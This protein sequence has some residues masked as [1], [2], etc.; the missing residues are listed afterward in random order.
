[1][2]SKIYLGEVTHAR[3]DPVKHQFRYPLYF[4]AFSLGELTQLDRQ[5][6]L[7]G[8]N[9]LRPV[10]IHDRDYLTPGEAP[11]REKLEDILHSSGLGGDLGEVVLVTAARYFNYI[12]NPISFFY[13]YDP[14]GA[15][16]CVLAQVNNTFGEMHLYP[17]AAEG[18][19]P[20]DGIRSLQVDKRF[21]VSPFFPRRGHYDFRL[22]EPGTSIDN[23]IRYHVDD[24]LSL[25]ARIHGRA[26]PLTAAA[27]ARTLM[28]HP[29]CASL[30]KPR[31]LWQAARLYWQRRLPVYPK[32]VP[33][34]ALTLRPAPP[35]LADRLGMA[36]T[37]KFLS[38]MP[39][40]ELVVTMP[41]GREYRF[42]QAGSEPSLD[43]TV[44]E[45]RFFRRVMVAGD[46]GFGEAF[47][48]GEWTTS[49]LPGLL[50]HLAAHESVMDDRSIVTSAVGRGL[51]FLRHVKRPNTLRGSAR[52][53]SEHYDLSNDF[54]ATFLDATMTYSGALFCSPDDSLEQAQ[55]NK[56]RCIL[57]KAGVTAEDHVLEIGCGWGSFAIEAARA[58]GCRVTGITVS[59][60]QLELARRRVADA[61][62][63]DRVEIR[64]CDYRHIRGSYSKVVSIEMLEAVGHAGLGAFFAACDRVLA[65]GG[66]AVVQV[67]TIPDR[68]YTAYRYS[69]DWIRKHIFPG[70]HLPS[71]GA[72]ARSIGGHSTLSLA[73]LTQSGRHY[74]RTLDCWTQRL[75]SSREEVLQMGYD[76]A[77]LR[78]WLYYF[79]YC[80]AGFD[81][82]IIDLTRLV[83][84]RPQQS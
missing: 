45:Y 30:T 53:I 43:M 49:D 35:S 52:N 25:V 34:S 79:A 42:G 75:S 10:S 19:D 81:A 76:E 60:E 2:K 58:T 33:D 66:R 37:L 26:R 48:D 18:H 40:G 11:M 55:R 82:Q 9:R 16:F 46:I 69:S 12:F 29:L 7:F 80:R 77:F 20:V 57:E 61:G 13:C 68:K 5:N 44:K 51:N 74:A 14:S 1:M 21:H 4:Y 70:G 3:S 63:Q 65:P 50:T 62:L 36:M 39:R 78:K 32:P 38:R 28:S 71:V 64:F 31:I 27:L 22:T 17:M 6:P 67:I 72:L 56:L 23:T 84:E 47:T 24:Q 54:F 83:L 59:R 15:L 73:E 41:D 8:Y